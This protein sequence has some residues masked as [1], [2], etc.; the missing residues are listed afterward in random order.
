MD[1]EI[2]EVRIGNK[3]LKAEVADTSAKRAKGLSNRQLLKKDQ[4][5]LFI[6][7]YAAKH[8]LW[9]RGMNFPIDVLWLNDKKRI[10]DIKTDLKPASGFLDFKM[11]APKEHANYVIELNAGFVES[12]KVSFSTKIIF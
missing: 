12:K 9:M 3:K 11:Y 6:F 1:Y 2:R 4:C 5:M 7:P 8:T 10:V